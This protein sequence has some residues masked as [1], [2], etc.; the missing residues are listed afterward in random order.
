MD[1]KSKTYVSFGFKKKHN[2][3]TWKQLKFD[4]NKHRCKKKNKPR[5]LFKRPSLENDTVEKS[6]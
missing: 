5:H 2:H 4:N 1:K 6:T 3:P